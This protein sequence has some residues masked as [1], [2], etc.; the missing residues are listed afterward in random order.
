MAH[1]AKIENNTVI[2]V[3]VADQEYINTLPGIWIKTSYNTH[4]GKHYDP[5]TGLEDSQEPLRKNYAAIGYSYDP[6]RDAFIPPKPYNSWILDEFSC[7]WKAPIN[8]PSDENN[9]YKWDEE[10]LEWIFN[11]KINRPI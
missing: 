10:N 2:E 11:G 1:F 4:G 5:E 9:L 7:L 3:I 6:E 8:D